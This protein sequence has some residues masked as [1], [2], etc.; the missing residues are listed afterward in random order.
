VT[1]VQT[2]ATLTGLPANLTDLNAVIVDPSG[3]AAAADVLSVVLLGPSCA[4]TASNNATMQADA[5][6]SAI[7]SA[8][9]GRAAISLLLPP[10]PA[11]CTARLL[12]SANHSGGA[13]RAEAALTYAAAC[14]YDA[15]CGGGRVVDLLRVR[16]AATPQCDTVAC[17]DPAALQDPMVVSSTPTRGSAQGGTIVEVC[18]N[19]RCAVCVWRKGWD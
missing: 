4:A 14:D 6:A 12:F 13:V 11:P 8:D 15:L 7:A 18:V 1:P 3:S 17:V 19:L 16:A 5:A 9:C 10:Q 2:T